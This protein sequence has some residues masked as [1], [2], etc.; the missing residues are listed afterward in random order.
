MIDLRCGNCLDLMPLIPDHSVDMI[1]CDLPY[2]TTACRWDTV[3][4]FEP[5]WTQYKR[6]IKG[7]GAIAL[8]AS[9]PFTSALVMS[10]IKW[11]RYCWV[12]DKLNPTG[13]LDANRKPLKRHEDVCIFYAKLPTYNPQKETRGEPR[14]KGGAKYKESSVYHHFGVKGSFNNEYFPTSIVMVSNAARNGVHPTQKPV[15][16]MEYLVKSLYQSKR[17]SPRQRYGIGHNRRSLRQ[18]GSP[19]HWHGA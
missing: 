16:L 13:H 9:Q 11:F 1:L 14:A 10:N 5:L 6:V 3:I 7:N 18:S 8:T 15:A 4:P 19:L 12:W 17:N 2:G